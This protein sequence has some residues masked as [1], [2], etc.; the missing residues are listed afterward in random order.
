MNLVCP[1]CETRFNIGS[2][3]IKPNGRM[4]KCGRCQ[5][6]WRAH[7]EDLTG[8]LAAPAAEPNEAAE[9]I[10]ETA[11]E[12]EP[13]VDLETGPEPESE[14]EPETR[15]ETGAESG[16]ETGP[17]TEILPQI[18]DEEPPLPSPE[19][20]ILDA[21]PEPIP[22]SLVTEIEEENRKSGWL[23]WLILLIVLAGLAAGAVFLRPQVIAVW[24]PASKLYGLVDGLLEDKY[25]GLE[26]AATP[27][28]GFKDGRQILTIRGEIAN[29]SGRVKDLAL[30]RIT[31]NDDKNGKLLHEVKVPLAKNLLAPNEKLKFSTVIPNPP[32]IKAQ[33]AMTF[34]DGG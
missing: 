23:G 33:I 32:E 17:E 25:A 6:T 16:P 34:I 18:A 31:L 19:E 24:P 28:Y 11:A 20:T 22:A 13:D 26:I 27:E 12:T 8:D 15:P 4:I 9:D 30:L 21:T 29:V 5:H 1:S 10:G 7:A 2:A 3:T 14:V